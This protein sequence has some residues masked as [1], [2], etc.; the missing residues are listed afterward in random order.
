M[1]GA[2]A[3]PT[4]PLDLRG[5]SC[6]TAG[7]CL[8]VGIGGNGF[9][10]AETWN[11]TT[12]R[13]TVSVRL[14][15]GRPQAAC[16]A[17]PAWRPH[18]ASRSATTTRSPAASSRSPKPGTARHGPRRSRPAPGSLFTALDG[19]SCT[20]AARCVAVGIYQMPDQVAAPLAEIWNGKRWTRT[21]PPASGPGFAI[22]GLN[23]VSCTS[24]AR[25]LAVGTPLGIPSVAVTEWLERHGLGGAEGSGRARGPGGRTDRRVLPVGAPLRSG[26]LLGHIRRR[27]SASARSGTASA[28]GTPPCHCQREQPAP[29]SCGVCPARQQNAASRSAIPSPWNTP[30]VAAR[31]PGTAKAWT[32]TSIPQPARQRQPVQ[33]RDLP[34]RG[35]LRSGRPGGPPGVGVHHRPDRLL[36]RQVLAP[37]HRAV[38]HHHPERG[39]GL[40][41]G[42][43]HCPAGCPIPLL[44]RC[45]TGGPAGR[46]GHRWPHRAT[47]GPRAVVSAQDRV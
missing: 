26:R 23:A 16:A 41:C 3:V 40:S 31:R 46:P 15:R 25:C 7:N 30:K 14:P 42:K 34:V 6:V 45:R 12:W 35:Q 17:S 38:E 24:P 20:S 33:R 8:A 22:S 13:R 5:V 4:V 2:A 32:V 29:R 37:G 1:A 28:G 19:V 36:E 39:G 11:G 21:R 43:R 10:L 9:P 47:A 44:Q 18:A 27:P